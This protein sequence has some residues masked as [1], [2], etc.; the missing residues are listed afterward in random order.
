MI[1]V[2][3]TK[4]AYF[5]PSKGYAVILSEWDGTRELP[6]VVGSTEAQAI[7][8]ALENVKMPRPLTHDLTANIIKELDAYISKVTIYKLQGETFLANIELVS[9]GQ[10]IKIDSRPSDAVAIALRTDTPIFVAENLLNHQH[11]E[12][13]EDENQEEDEAIDDFRDTTFEEKIM[14]LKSA[15]GKA[16]EDENYEVAAK[17]RDQLTH[18]RK[19]R[20]QP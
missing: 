4:I 3:V 17:L 15:L 14:F 9:G 1:K 20:N 12:F 18:F 13:P 10:I 5:P 8:F 11:I 19:V 2:D 7:A 16:I 6:I